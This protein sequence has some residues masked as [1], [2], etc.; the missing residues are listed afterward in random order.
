MTID[1]EK[2]LKEYMNEMEIR[3]NRLEN[4][5]KP[6]GIICGQ[7]WIV[8]VKGICVTPE[9]DKDGQT[10][11]VVKNNDPDLVMRF[12]QEDAEMLAST[13]TNGAGDKGESVIWADAVRDL[14]E[15]LKPQL[16]ILKNR[17]K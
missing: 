4:S 17:K 11:G 15:E 16:E 8:R 9:F 1:V 10:T 7:N 14:I 6:R 5:I 3:L 12:V 13:T 2:F